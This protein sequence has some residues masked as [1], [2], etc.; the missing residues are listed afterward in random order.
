[1]L[2]PDSV[3]RTFPGSDAVTV[4]Q[5]QID[6]FAAIVGQSDTSI[7]PPTFAIRITLDQSQVIFQTLR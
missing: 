7:A 3:G 5:S 4:T 6:A 1:M 2:N